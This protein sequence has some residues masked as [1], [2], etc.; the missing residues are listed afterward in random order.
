MWFESLGKYRAPQSR[1]S[2]K[3]R[4]HGAAA[5]TSVSWAPSVHFI[6]ASQLST[7]GCTDQSID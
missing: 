2:M 3:M 5:T 1:A 7:F 6:G 4:E